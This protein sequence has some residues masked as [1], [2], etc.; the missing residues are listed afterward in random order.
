[1][2]PSQYP[3]IADGTLVPPMP[4]PAQGY[5]AIPGI[6]YSGKLNDMYVNDNFSF[7]TRHTGQPYM[8]LVP[9]TDRDG[10]DLAGIR[11]TVIQAPIGTYAG[12]N[13]RRAGFIEGEVCGTNGSYV[14]F[15]RKA[16]DRG[17]DPRLSLEERYH[18]H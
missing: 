8:V 1:P 10:N 14:P 15:A 17:S 12:W 2:P 7:P 9:K 18:T 4:Q 16:A 5:P 13:L 6:R 3:K 11:S